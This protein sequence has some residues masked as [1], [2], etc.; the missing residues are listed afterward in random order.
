MPLTLGGTCFRK[1]GSSKI[2]KNLSYR[3]SGVVS[4]LFALVVR[5][6][7]SDEHGN[8]SEEGPELDEQ[9]D[10]MHPSPRPNVSPQAGTIIGKIYLAGN[11][12]K[13]FAFT[14]KARWRLSSP[15]AYRPTLE[16]LVNEM[17][18]LPGLLSRTRK[19]AVFRDGRLS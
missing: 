18:S 4:Q 5:P 1:S 16:L 10:P 13:F 8:D 15:G 3:F 12:E 11:A 9:L 7:H 14:A 17:A 2:G 19:I 6:E